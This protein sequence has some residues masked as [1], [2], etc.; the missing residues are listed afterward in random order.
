MSDRVLSDGAVEATFSVTVLLSEPAGTL[1]L[2]V[3]NERA[4][5]TGARDA[6][7]V[8]APP[9][10]EDEVGDLR[11]RVEEGRATG[12][13]SATAAAAAAA[14]A[15]LSALVGSGWAVAKYG[16]TVDVAADGGW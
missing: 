11:R 9:A 8:G 2:T 15:A 4:A 13:G 5:S 3:E 7:G 16:A 10:R 1:P 6:A 14:H 12:F